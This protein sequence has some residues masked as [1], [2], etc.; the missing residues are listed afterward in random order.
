MMF[1]AT[2][3]GIPESPEIRP[4]NPSQL[5]VEHIGRYFTP[6]VLICSSKAR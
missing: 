4:E 6:D 3:A 1:R 2:L 5:K